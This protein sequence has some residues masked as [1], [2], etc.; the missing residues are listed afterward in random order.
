VTALLAIDFFAEAVVFEWLEW[1]FTTKH[2][3]FFLLWW[4]AVAGW[5]VLSARRLRLLSCERSMQIFRGERS[6]DIAVGVELLRELAVGRIEFKEHQCALRA[7]L[8]H[9]YII[10][11][12]LDVIPHTSDP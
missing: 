7:S 2:D 5:T 4:L 12:L 11:R 3:W 8:F 1:N 6:K 9:V 10:R